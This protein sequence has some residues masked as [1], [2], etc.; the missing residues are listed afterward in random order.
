MRYPPLEVFFIGT[1]EHVVIKSE[2]KNGKESHIEI[3]QDQI[4]LLIKAL[5]RMYAI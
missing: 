3:N 2:D 5:E 1:P 4:P